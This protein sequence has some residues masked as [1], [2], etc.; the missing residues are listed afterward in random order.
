VASCKGWSGTATKIGGVDTDGAFLEGTVTRLDIEDYCRRDHGGQTVA[1]GG[2][3]TLRQ[4]VDRYFSK[5]G[6]TSLLT[7]ANCMTSTIKFYKG[8]GKPTFF[9]MVPSVNRDPELNWLDIDAG[10]VLGLS[11]A[12][13]TPPIAAQMEIL[14]PAAM[15][16]ARHDA[17]QR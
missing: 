7:R 3:L 8:N 11:C 2:K 12:D 15:K 16:A 10:N 17:T 14:C 9:K 13:G 5:E 1:S 6:G 4:C